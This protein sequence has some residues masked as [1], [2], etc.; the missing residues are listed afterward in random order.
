[1]R[2]GAACTQRL[3]YGCPRDDFVEHPIEDLFLVG[4]G[5]ESAGLGHIVDL[6]ISEEPQRNLTAY[7]GNLHFRE[8]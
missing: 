5:R 3:Q 2:D 6:K 7:A 8:D 4:S 1:M